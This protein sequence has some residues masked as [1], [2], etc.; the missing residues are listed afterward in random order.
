MIG[1]WDLNIEHFLDFLVAF[2]I[3]CGGGAPTAGSRLRHV[4]PISAICPSWFGVDYSA[5]VISGLVS[6][7]GLDGVSS[8]SNR[9]F[10]GAQ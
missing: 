4:L 2:K 3:G 7:E 5:L 8:V 10:S 9:K 1:V 6:D